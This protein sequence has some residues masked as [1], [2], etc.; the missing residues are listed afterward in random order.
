M[1]QDVDST[2]PQRHQ[3]QQNMVSSLKD[4]TL[5]RAIIGFET[6]W[7]AAAADALARLGEELELSDVQ[8]YYNEP[9]VC[10]WERVIHE[11]M[12]QENNWD[13]IAPQAQTEQ[14]RK[15]PSE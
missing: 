3:Q 15:Q 2:N 6:Q 10:C 8:Q 1:A 5:S 13:T 11:G 12:E 4:R 7:Y 14:L 9:V